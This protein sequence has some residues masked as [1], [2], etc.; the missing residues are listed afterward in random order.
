MRVAYLDP[1]SGVSG[2]LLLGALVDVGVP[3]AV[4]QAAVDTLGGGG[5][6][7]KPATVLRHGVSGTRVDVTYP[8]QHE[9]RCLS[10]IV[11]MIAASGLPAGVRRQAIAVF[12]RLAEVEAAVHEV[13]VDEIHF[14]EVGAADALA[15]VVGAVT[16]FDA[17]AVERVLV[18][19]VNVGSGRVT[20]AHGTLPVPAPATAGLLEGWMCYVAG[21]RR[22]LTTPTGAAVVTTLGEQVAA[23]PALRVERAGHGAASCDPPG[24]ANVLRLVVGETAALPPASS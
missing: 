22:E 10:D 7:L 20:C 15:D 8:E 21:P 13:A 12:T 6:S 16:G 5:L 1:S 24:W 18:G 11:A 2:D 4:L 19:P 17:L 14:H 23:M 9:H 3:L